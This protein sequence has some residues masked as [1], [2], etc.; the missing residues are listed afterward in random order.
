LFSINT[1]TNDGV[2]T[3]QNYTYTDQFNI[4]VGTSFS[5]PIVSGM[6][7][8]MASVN[9]T[10]TPAQMIS[11]LRQSATPYPVSTDPNAPP[12]CPAV[13]GNDECSCTTSTCGAGM[14]NAD[15]ALQAALRPT[16]VLTA[17]ASV[18]SGQVVALSAVGSFVADG[19]VI[20]SYLW[21]VV[22]GTGSLTSTNTS[23]TT[24]V[25]PD[26]GSVTVRLT[27]TDDA[28]RQDFAQWSF[29]A[30][31]VSVTPNTA[32]VQASGGSQAFTATVANAQNT[33]VT[34]QVN[35]VTGGNATV[36][37][38]SVFGGYSAPASVPTPATVTVTAVSIQDPTRTAAAQL[39]ITAPPAPTTPPPPPASSGGGGGGAF[40]LLCLLCVVTL[41]RRFAPA[42]LRA[43][44]AP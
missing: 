29:A 10:M 34:W 25:A 36:G 27:V 32:N 12:M 31:S 17:P 43:R 23:D 28:G 26:S 6:L 1:T 35:G 37:V 7:G 30:I 42:L 22:S 40:D 11:R 3:A 20:S 16:A 15:G 18:T 13:N 24:I 39:T 14:A 33:G 2:T 4:N 5:A 44:R 41:S 19:R 9:G 38:I 8:L 21:E